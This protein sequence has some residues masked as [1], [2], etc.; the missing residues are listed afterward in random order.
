MCPR[1]TSFSMEHKRS[2]F[3]VNILHPMNAPE[4]NTLGQKVVVFY[5]LER[6]FE[7]AKD[8][9]LAKKDIDPGINVKCSSKRMGMG[10]TIK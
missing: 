8:E 4:V 9:R 6:T 1:F 3:H 5:Q 7:D 10:T 2:T